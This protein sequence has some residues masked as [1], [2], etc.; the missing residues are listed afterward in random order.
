M[1]SVEWARKEQ[2][3]YA[4]SNIKRNQ[5]VPFWVYI[6]ADTVKCIICE[7]VFVYTAIQL[8]ELTQKNIQCKSIA[9]LIPIQM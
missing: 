2:K 5:I 8:C 3:H 4:E 7:C 9:P 6:S 1:C